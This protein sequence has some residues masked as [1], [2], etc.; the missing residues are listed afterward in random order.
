MLPEAANVHYRNLRESPFPMAPPKA[1]VFNIPASAPFLPV[2][3]RALRDGRLIE[4]FPD[5]TDPLSLGRATIY[6]PTQRACRLARDIFLDVTQDS[7]AI[8]PRIVPLG[9][10]DEDELI[11]AEML[12]P[13]AAPALELPETLDPLSRRLR[14][15]ELISRWAA[16]AGMTGAFSCGA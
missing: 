6:L 16:S 12:G 3:I 2:L 5:R 11:F 4:G 1:N 7:A 9:D 13:L 15:A 14:L 8:L 10:I